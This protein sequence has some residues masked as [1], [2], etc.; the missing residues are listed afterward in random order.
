M[1]LTPSTWSQRGPLRGSNVSLVGGNTVVLCAVRALRDKRW[2]RTPFTSC[3]QLTRPVV[4]HPP[5]VEQDNKIY[6]PKDFHDLEIWLQPSFAS[7]GEKIGYHRDNRQARSVCLFVGLSEY[8]V[9]RRKG[10]GWLQTG[11]VPGA[12]AREFRTRQNGDS[13]RSGPRY[14][15]N[16]LIKHLNNFLLFVHSCAINLSSRGML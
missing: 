6:L 12:R 5:L 8:W 16:K 7:K 3:Q 11:T 10:L 4:S 14:K 9:Q 15:K 1:P 13:P 2:A